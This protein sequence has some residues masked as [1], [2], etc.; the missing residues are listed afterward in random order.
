MQPR[1]SP[2]PSPFFP[3]P[4][5]DDEA[6]PRSDHIDRAMQ[7]RACTPYSLLR[8]PRENSQRFA[9]SSVSR[10]PWQRPWDG[11]RGTGLIRANTH[12]PRGNSGALSRLGVNLVTP[13]VAF[14][15]GL[16]RWRKI[17]LERQNVVQPVASTPNSPY[18]P[19]YLSSR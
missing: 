2:H 5:S 15:R 9:Q 16:P 1:Y 3:S 11:G 8:K 18:R 10:V 4:S 17:R 19:G 7:Q 13:T 12:R 14:N 6:Q